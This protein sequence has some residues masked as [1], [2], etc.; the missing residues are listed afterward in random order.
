MENQK[1]KVEIELNPETIK[2]IEDIVQYMNLAHKYTGA[3]Y[4]GVSTEDIIKAAIY[5]YIEVSTY[6]KQ[7]D[8]GMSKESIQILNNFKEIMQ[9]RNLKQIEL[10]KRTG[11]DKAT[12]SAILNNHN[13]PNL[14]NFLK[15]IAVLRTPVERAITVNKEEK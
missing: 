14:L 11:I 12:L 9:S 8:E 1:I 10:S 2:E 3:F 7:F 4:E 6:F 13:Q 5:Y 15:L